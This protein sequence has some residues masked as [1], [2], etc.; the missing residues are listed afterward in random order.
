MTRNADHGHHTG[1]RRLRKSLSKRYKLKGKKFTLRDLITLSE[2]ALDRLTQLMPTGQDLPRG[3][4]V[5]YPCRG[6]GTVD[7]DADVGMANQTL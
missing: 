5:R 3:T 2:R 6:L 4:R 1:P 7:S